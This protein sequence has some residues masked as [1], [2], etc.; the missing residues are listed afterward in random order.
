MK[1]KNAALVCC[2]EWYYFKKCISHKT[3]L[4][5]PLNNIKLAALP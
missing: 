5:T 2:N 3:G 4:V 1:T